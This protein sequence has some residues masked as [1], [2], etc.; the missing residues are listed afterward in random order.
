MNII[1]TRDRQKVHR[2]RRRDRSRL[3]SSSVASGDLRGTAFNQ[4]FICVG[5]FTTRCQARAAPRREAEKKCG[6]RNKQ[7]KLK[8]K[9]L[10]RQR[11]AVFRCV[12]RHVIYRDTNNEQAVPPPQSHTAIS[13]RRVNLDGVVPKYAP[14][15]FFV[16]LLI[17][18][19][20]HFFNDGK[21]RTFYSGLSRMIQNKMCRRDSENRC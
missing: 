19:F 17:F 20:Y 12:F 18:F 2:R 5:L 10:N 16:L 15:S 21:D 1:I 14:P 8:L 3:D 11:F 9:W 7:E 6:R 4:K 13:T